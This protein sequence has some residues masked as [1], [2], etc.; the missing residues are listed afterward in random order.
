MDFIVKD[1]LRGIYGDTVSID[2]MGDIRGVKD[3][4]LARHLIKVDFNRMNVVIGV[5]VTSS[6]IW[7]KTLESSRW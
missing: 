2:R 7:W 4:H 5:H 1:Y 3:K 6:M